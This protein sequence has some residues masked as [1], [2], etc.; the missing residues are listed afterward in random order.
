V[1]THPGADI[2]ALSACIIAA[3]LVMVGV[4]ATVGWAIRK[5]LFSV[6]PSVFLLWQ[7]LLS[8]DSSFLRR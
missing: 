1:K 8:V 7:R 2:I 5:G 3:Q 4:A 6:T